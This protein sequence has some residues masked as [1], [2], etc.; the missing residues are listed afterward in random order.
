MVVPPHQI[1]K[2]REIFESR[3]LAVSSG[4]LMARCLLLTY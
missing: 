2:R 3:L 1:K 4:Q